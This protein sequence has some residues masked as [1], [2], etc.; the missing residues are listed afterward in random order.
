[1]MRRA[2]F[3]LVLA[4]GLAAAAEDPPLMCFGNE[5]SWSLALETPDR[6]RLTLPDEAPAE[7]RGAS[8]RIEPLRERVWRG[9]LE[10]GAGGDLV[11]FLREADCSDG[12]SDVTHPVFVR[13]SL[14]DGRFRAGCCRITS[15]GA[16]APPASAALEGPV[17]RLVQLRGQTEAALAGVQN[18]V[19]IRFEAG[20]LQGFG[21][22]NHLSGTYTIDRDRVTLGALVGTLMACAQPA[23]AIETAFKDAFSGSLLVRVAEGRL[24]LASESDPDPRLVFEAM[25]PPRL[26]ETSW[27]V[28]GFNNGRQAVVSPLAGTTLTLSFED[29]SV[30]GHAG[31]NNF[32][33]RYT[34]EGN[35][36]ALGPVAA[37][38]KACAEE[39][40]MDQ[41]RQLLAAIESAT[42]WTIDRDV[43]EL[44][45]ADGER[46]LTARKRAN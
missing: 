13:V 38:R 45:R 14:P 22:C 6:A 42:T 2:A 25:P 29:G 8:T 7:Y 21:G 18:G 33:G 1:M 4:S 46:V 43:L 37:T 24:T 28:T 41:E 35:R 31:C 10:S 26:E 34:T 3:G 15:S 5:P 30:A 19:T 17:W 16:A 32:R 39:G 36:I 27:E 12:M 20:R 40:V 11:A 23:M 44:H 9:K